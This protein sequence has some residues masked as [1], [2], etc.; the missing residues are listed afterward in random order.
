MLE[1]CKL[2]VPVLAMITG[3][4]ALSVPTFWLPNVKLSGAMADAGAPNAVPVSCTTCEKPSFVETA[5]V[6]PLA[7]AAVGANITLTEHWA[8]SPRPDG[9]LLVA[10]NPGVA[11]TLE[12]ANT[13]VP[14]FVIVTDCGALDVPMA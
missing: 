13:P 1:I 14:L 5:T 9:Q 6:P 3:C 2:A 10:R 7:P 11:C 8:P 12:I 4:A